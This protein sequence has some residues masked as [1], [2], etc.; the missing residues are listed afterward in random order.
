MWWVKDVKEETAD[1]DD[2]DANDTDYYKY[3]DEKEDRVR[4]R[5][6]IFRKRNNWEPSHSELPSLEED[7]ETTT[8]D[9]PEKTEMKEVKPSGED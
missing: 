6:E 2:D 4:R 9:E 3:G 1:S 7:E 5:H 8:N